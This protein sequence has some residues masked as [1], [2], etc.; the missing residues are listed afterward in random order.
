MIELL[1]PGWIA[2]MLLAIAAEASWFFCCMAPNVLFWRYVGM[3]LY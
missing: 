1:L 3:P 2:G